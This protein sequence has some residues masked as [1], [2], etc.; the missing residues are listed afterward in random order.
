MRKK[1]IIGN[2]GIKV[3]KLAKIQQKKYPVQNIK[4]TNYQQYTNDGR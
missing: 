1:S 3:K 4:N 2:D